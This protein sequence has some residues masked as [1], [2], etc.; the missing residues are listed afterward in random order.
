VVDGHAEFWN[1]ITN[2]AGPVLS[3][4][5]NVCVMDR[6]DYNKNS[7]LTSAAVPKYPVSQSRLKELPKTRIGGD[8]S[9]DQS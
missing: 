9:C 7:A 8:L 1:N 5:N 4:N 6:D 2:I 3:C